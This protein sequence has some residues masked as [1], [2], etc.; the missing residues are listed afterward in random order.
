MTIDLDLYVAD[1]G[2]DRF[3]LFR[4][5]QINGMTLVGNG[6]NGTTIAL[7]CPTGVMLDV[8]GYLFIFDQG[9]LGFSVRSGL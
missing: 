6:S 7:D 9:S 2:N 4:E 8:D 1:C 5:G 3:Q